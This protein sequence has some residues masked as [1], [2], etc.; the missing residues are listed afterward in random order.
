MR[1]KN[2]EKQII[3]TDEWIMPNYDDGLFISHLKRYYFALKFAVNKVVLDAGCGAGYG[4]DLL[5]TV[6]KKVIGIDYS[7][8]AIDCAR[9]RYS[10][11]NLKFRQKNLLALDFNDNTFDLATCF[12][13]IEHIRDDYMLL[14]KISH[15]LKPNGVLVINTPNRLTE[16]L[17]MKSIN[18]KNLA[19]VNLMSSK[20]LRTRLS[21]FFSTV[22]LYGQRRKP[23]TLRYAFYSFLKRFDMFNLRLRLAY[24]KRKSILGKLGVANEVPSL[25]D[26]EI[27]KG[28]FRQ[29]QNLIAVCRKGGI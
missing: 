4:G 7:L 8:K 10:R 24:K 6:A 12:E 23:R 1:R 11:S 17:H 13:V 9:K 19:H 3:S 20:E 14:K 26:F 21:R 25:E 15:I 18:T 29:C 5:A 16:H 28:M 22:E 2:I 27:A